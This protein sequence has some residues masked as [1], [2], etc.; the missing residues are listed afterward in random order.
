MVD[1]KTHEE[2]IETIV[3]YKK[4]MR[5]L[6]TG[7]AEL[8]RLSGLSPEIAACLLKS[9]KRNNVTQIRGYSKERPEAIE[10]KKGTMYEAKK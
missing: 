2:I 3:D 7:S 1:P 8:S 10:A 4:G 6:Q 9:M 5:N